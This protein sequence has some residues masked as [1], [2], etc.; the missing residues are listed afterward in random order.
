[1]NRAVLVA[2]R[3][4]DRILLPTDGS[5]GMSSAI[6]QCL[7][8]ARQHDATVHALYV[9]DVRAYVMLPEETRDRVRELL[10]AE[11]ERAMAALQ[12]SFDDAGV[13][14]RTEIREGVPH[15]EILGYA[16]DHDVDLVVMGTH[17]QSGASN[18]IVGSVAEEVVRNAT[19]PVLTVRATGDDR[20]VPSESADEDADVDEDAEIAEEQSRYIS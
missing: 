20:G 12:E 6:E 16:D 15:E 11:G 1:M 8:Q 18:R 2:Y 14:L 4:Y 17:G 10:A 13:D 19:T 7:H 9:V 3:M 5:A